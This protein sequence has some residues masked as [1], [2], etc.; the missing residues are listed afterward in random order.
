MLSKAAIQAV[1]DICGNGL[2]GQRTLVLKPNAFIGAAVRA[3][4]LPANHPVLAG[5]PE[6]AVGFKDGLTQLEEVLFTFS[7]QSTPMGDV[8]ENELDAIVGEVTRRVSASLDFA[9]NVI[10][11]VIR[12]LAREVK[13]LRD[14]YVGEG[15]QDSKID[16]LHVLPIYESEALKGIYENHTMYG[17]EK[18]LPA[19]IV[20]MINKDLTTD[21]LINTCK[22][23]LSEIDGK[24]DNFIRTHFSDIVNAG[25]SFTLRDVLNKNHVYGPGNENPF[26]NHTALLGYLYLNGI[27]SNRKADFN[28]D[29]ADNAFRKTIMNRRNYFAKCLANQ[30]AAAE[31]AFAPGTIAVHAYSRPDEGIYAVNSK[32]YREWVKEDDNG[33]AGTYVAFAVTGSRDEALL[34]QNSE[35]YAKS[36]EKMEKSLMRTNEARAD[37]ETNQLIHRYLSEVIANEESIEESRKHDLQVKLNERIKAKRYYSALALDEYLLN[38]TCSVIGNGTDVYEALTIMRAEMED[39]PDLT[40]KAAASLAAIQLLANWAADQMCWENF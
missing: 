12:D 29:E 28:V 9:S 5:E 36:W 32:L 22:T 35:A 33:S 14:T 6:L 15:L 34:R 3:S 30:Q 11:P 16:F 39:D 31:R 24:I 13:E 26:T 8:H 25:F 19:N 20:S 2:Y 17:E 7:K 38:I 18:A 4:A 1:R 37:N 21:S 40:P 27:L 23:G 10:N